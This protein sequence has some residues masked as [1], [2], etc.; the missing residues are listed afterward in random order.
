VAAVRT[1]LSTGEGRPT[2]MNSEGGTCLT[3]SRNYSVISRLI[4]LTII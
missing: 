3:V 1:M 2:D 4:V